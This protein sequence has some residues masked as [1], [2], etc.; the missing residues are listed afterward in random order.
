M[1]DET[2]AITGHSQQHPVIAPQTKNPQRINARVLGISGGAVMPRK[3]TRH[4]NTWVFPRFNEK[5]FKRL[6]I[7]LGKDF[8]RMLVLLVDW[9]GSTVWF[10]D[11]S[12]NA[13]AIRKDTENGAVSS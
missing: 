7:L 5:K 1:L 10:N 3:Q 11:S 12:M 8:Q 6:P 4:L 13:R 2:L 9:F